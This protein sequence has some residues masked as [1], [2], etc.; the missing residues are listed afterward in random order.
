LSPWTS[1][2]LKVHLAA[3]VDELSLEKYPVSPLDVAIELLGGELEAFVLFCRMGHLDPPRADGKTP[4]GILQCASEVPEID[5]L[6][7]E[8]AQQ[9]IL[10]QEQRS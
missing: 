5:G 10:E 9:W 3:L 1:D 8:T 7:R 2:E 6:I 4:I